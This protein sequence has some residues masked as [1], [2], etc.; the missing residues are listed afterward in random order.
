MRKFENGWSSSILKGR[1]AETIVEEMLVKSEYKVYRFGYE[2]LLQNL[3]QVD[4]MKNSSV[5]DKIRSMPD[6][7][8]IDKDGNASFV[9]VKFSK[10]GV[11]GNKWKNRVK[12]YWGDGRLILVTL[13]KPYFWI[14]RI[15]EYLNKNELYKLHEDKFI[16]V[17]KKLVDKYSFFVEKYFKKDKNL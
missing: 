10:S 16:K 2:G 11:V 9:E 8:V 14:S 5:S 7:V 4:R 15:E 1:I 12:D 17:D 3:A 13:K 6:F